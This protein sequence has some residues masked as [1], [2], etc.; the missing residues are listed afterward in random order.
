MESAFGGRLYRSSIDNMCQQVI[1]DSLCF[2]KSYVVADDKQDLPEL[3]HDVSDYLWSSCW[4]CDGRALVHLSPLA[5]D[6]SLP[7]HMFLVNVC[8]VSGEG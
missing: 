1:S 7:M 8:V 6:P 5:L 4:L 2:R 3:S